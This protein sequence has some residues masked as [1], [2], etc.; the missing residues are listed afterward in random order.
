M[1]PDLRRFGC[2]IEIG[3]RRL[4]VWAARGPEQLA[5]Q[6]TTGLLLIHGFPTSSHDWLPIWPQL[7]ARFPLLAPDLLGLGLS[8]K[9][10]PHRYTVLEQAELIDLLLSQSEIPRW[11]I[12]AHD[13]GDSVAQELLARHQEGRLSVRLGGLC[14]LNGGLFP[15][16]HRPLLVQRLLA[17]AAG[18]MLARLLGRKAFERGMNK[19]C[20]QPWPPGELDHAWQILCHEQGRRVLPGLLAYMEERREHRRRWLRAMGEC[21]LPILLINGP[22]DPVSG[23]HL[24]ARFTE[25]LPAAELHSLPGV[26][27]YPQL[28]AP[29]EVLQ[30]A[31]AFYAR[32]DGKDS[33]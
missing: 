6:E 10:Y 29:A 14:L 11:H 4:F 16:A 33:N 17:S 32:I 2:D 21:E 5:G 18:P 23:R 27:H 12:L 22:E 7:A 1:N 15:E 24:A 19:I 9:P 30:A 3:G 20:R 31:L 26:G 25:L 13:L 28:E 8:E